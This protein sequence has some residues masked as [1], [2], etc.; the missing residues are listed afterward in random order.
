MTACATGASR[1]SSRDGAAPLPDCLLQRAGRSRGAE[2]RS[3]TRPPAASGCRGLRLF[4][5]I[6]LPPLGPSLFAATSIVFIWAFTELGVPLLCDYHART[7]VQFFSGLKDLG[8]NPFVYALLVVLGRHGRVSACSRLP[9][10]RPRGGHRLGGGEG[11]A[12]PPP[13]PPRVRCAAHRSSRCSRGL[14]GRRRAPRTPASCSSLSRATGTHSCPRVSP[15]ITCAAAPAHDSSC[16][17][18]AT[19]SATSRSST[20]FDLVVGRRSPT[21]SCA[22]RARLANAT[23]RRRDAPRSRA[24]PVMAFGD[25]S[26]TREGRPLSF[27][28]PVPRIPR[29]CWSSP[30][31]SAACPSSSA[32]R[33]PGLTHIARRRW[34]RPPPASAPAAMSRFARV[35]LP[36]WRVTC[37]PAPSSPSRSPCSRSRTP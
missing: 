29:R 5:K 23:R 30:T 37:S 21:W 35:T 3:S 1:W 25:R 18:S 28:N 2:S 19:A 16:P 9:A 33:R 15:S 17:P 36:C 20:A 10:V 7:S 32:P 14:R 27:L 4:R 34:R 31:P 12:R 22:C 6:T 24:G 8:R 13:A 26:T 11:G